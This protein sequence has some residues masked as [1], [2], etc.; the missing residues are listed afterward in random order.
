MQNFR[1]ISIIHAVS[2][3]SLGFVLHSLSG[4]S[5]DTASDR[6][7]ESNAILIMDVMITRTF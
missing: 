1:K 7:L 6:K 3:V 4:W 5:R 2:L